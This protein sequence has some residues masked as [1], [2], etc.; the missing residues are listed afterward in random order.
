MGIRGDKAIWEAE[1]F[2]LQLWEITIGDL[3]DQ[4]AQKLPD[5]E[6]IVYRYSELKLVLR[7]NYRQYQT[8]VNQLAKGLLALGIDKGVHVAIWAPNLPEWI[9]LQLALAKIGA[10]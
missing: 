10:G 3:L 2:G 8:Q 7:L 5:K 4:Q 6:A 1:A 9:F